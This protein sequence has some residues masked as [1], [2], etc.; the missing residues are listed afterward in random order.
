MCSEPSSL[1]GYSTPSLGRRHSGFL[2]LLAYPQ[3]PSSALL[4]FLPSRR[5]SSKNGANCQCV[6]CRPAEH[7]VRALDG[8]RGCFF[9]DLRDAHDVVGERPDNAS[10]GTQSDYTHKR[11]AL[12]DEVENLRHP[13]VCVHHHHWGGVD[14]PHSSTR[15]KSQPLYTPRHRLCDEGW[16]GIAQY[17]TGKEEWQRTAKITGRNPFLHG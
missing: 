16:W 9:F 10:K 3:V 7:C 17:G 13:P 4:L 6:L 11:G 1:T 5:V 14:L 2:L 12:A 15:N 8:Q